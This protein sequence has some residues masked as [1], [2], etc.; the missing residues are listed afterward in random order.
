[1]LETGTVEKCMI[2]AL[3]TV[4]NFIAEMTG[5]KPTQQEIAHALKRYFVLNEIKAHIIMEREGKKP[6]PAS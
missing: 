3:E 1:M 6:I 4:E 5:K 2:D